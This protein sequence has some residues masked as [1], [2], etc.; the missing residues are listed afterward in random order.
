MIKYLFHSGE[1]T[2]VLDS[3]NQVSS[4]IFFLQHKL[5]CV[6]NW[7]YTPIESTKNIYSSNGQCHVYI[8][9][10]NIRYI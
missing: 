8:L 3:D 10:G 1:F 7:I 6:Q 2:S 5:L 9:Y 4:C